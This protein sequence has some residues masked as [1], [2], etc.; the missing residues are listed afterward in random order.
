M[1]RKTERG[2]KDKERR[3]KRKKG[4]VKQNGSGLKNNRACLERSFNI[5]E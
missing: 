3:E 4:K 5:Y 1:K 2:C